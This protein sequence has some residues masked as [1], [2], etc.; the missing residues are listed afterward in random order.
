MNNQSKKVLIIGGSGFIGRHLT[1]G[2]LK[3]GNK[4]RILDISKPS[5]VPADVEF[6]EG[7]F[8]NEH[9]LEESLTDCETV[10]HLASTTLPKTSNEDPLFDV[11]SNLT[12][13]IRLLQFAVRLNVKKFIFS[14]SGGTVYGI[15]D[16]FPV[17]ENSPTFPTCSYGIVKL[18]IEKYLRLFYQLYGLDTCSLRISNPY[19]EYQRIDRSHGAV[20]VFCAKT[21]KNET[22]EIWGDG[23]IAR[24]FIYIEDVISAMI[25]AMYCKCYG[26]EINI[27]SGISKS[28]NDIIVIIQNLTNRS[29]DVKFLPPRNFDVQKTYLAIEKAEEMLNWHPKINLEEGIRKTIEWLMYE[30]NTNKTSVR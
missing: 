21:L 27:G 2:L 3:N 30:L 18:T 12:G 6:I 14:S 24:D 4:V 5:W 15:S 1:N 16:T 17:S 13:T 25:N 22:I 26:E 11:S 20:T 19:G 7:S 8:V 28:L 10:F 29:S 9:I 23:S